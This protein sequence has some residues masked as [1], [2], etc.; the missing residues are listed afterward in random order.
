MSEIK[1]E[2]REF[3]KL[4]LQKISRDFGIRIS[5][6]KSVILLILFLK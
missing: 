5:D 1:Q 4:E 2:Q 6:Y 3:I